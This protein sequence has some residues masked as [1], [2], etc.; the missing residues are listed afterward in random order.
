MDSQK[1]NQGLILLR[2]MIKETEDNIEDN[3][4]RIDSVSYISDQIIDKILTLTDN[5]DQNKEKIINI[6]NNMNN[7]SSNEDDNN[8]NN[9]LNI[10]DELM[11]KYTILETRLNSIEEIL[12]NLTNTLKEMDKKTINKKTGKTTARKKKK[13]ID[14]QNINMF[15]TNSNEDNKLVDTILKQ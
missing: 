2:N 3:K 11:D 7:N 5:Y 8:Q 9:D 13:E 4:S 10:C 15:I 12:E 14:D 1:I 6:E